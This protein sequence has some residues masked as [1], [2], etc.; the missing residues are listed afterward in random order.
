[1]LVKIIYISTNN[2]TN[3]LTEHPRF[4]SNYNTGT[5]HKEVRSL[6]RR[7]DNGTFGKSLNSYFAS[8]SNRV[9]RQILSEAKYLPNMNKRSACHPDE[10]GIFKFVIQGH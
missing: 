6:L 3:N 2:G 9:V 1:M 8:L 10:G 5:W 4:K 7:D